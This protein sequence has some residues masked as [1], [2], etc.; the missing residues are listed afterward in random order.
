LCGGVCGETVDCEEYGIEEGEGELG[1]GV[2]N[3]F[4]DDQK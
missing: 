3:N 4:E 1:D 2:G